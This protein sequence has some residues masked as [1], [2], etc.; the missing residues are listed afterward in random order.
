MR[1]I[2]NQIFLPLCIAI[3]CPIMWI[4]CSSLPEISKKEA[5]NNLPN[6]IVEAEGETLT[7]KQAELEAKTLIAIS[8]IKPKQLE[9]LDCKMTDLGAESFIKRILVAKELGRRNITITK[10]E[11]DKEIRQILATLDPEAISNI[12]EQNIRLFVQTKI[13]LDKLMNDINLD[14]PEKEISNYCAKNPVPENVM[15]RH[16]QITVYSNDSESSKTDKRKQIEAIRKQLLKGA[17]FATLAR[18]HSNCPSAEKGGYLGSFKR[19]TMKKPIEDA[20]FSQEVNTIG[21]IIKT[22]EG[23]HII[24]TLEH[25]KTQPLPRE[26]VIKYLK[27]KKQEENLKQLLADLKKNAAIK[28]YRDSVRTLYE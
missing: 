2:T 6:I 26:I 14:I 16:I 10:S 24:Q 22:D 21:P 8:G 17:N 13:A 3:T 19:G 28:D 20:A 12:P 25:N 23:Y 11:E 18:K 27:Q 15:A 7:R 4:G 1:K 9:K 5:E